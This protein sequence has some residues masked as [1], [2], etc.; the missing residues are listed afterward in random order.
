MAREI[1]RRQL[2]R[3]A[4][5]LAGLA[6]AG[7]CWMCGGQL[8]SRWSRLVEARGPVAPGRVRLPAMHYLV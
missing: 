1:T 8:A 5:G 2:L 3:Q 6:G 4:G 7:R